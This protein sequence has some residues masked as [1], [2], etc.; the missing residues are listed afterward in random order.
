LCASNDGA[1]DCGTAAT[2]PDIW[3]VFT[4]LRPGVLSVSLCGS[5]NNAGVD[6]GPDT[7]LSIHSG[8]P[9]TIANEL[10]CNDDG[11]LPGCN[12]LDS[13]ARL[14]LP[15]PA[16]VRIRVSHFGSN[17]FRVGNGV[18]AVHAAY[19]C[20]ADY[21]HNGHVEPADINLFV[22]TWFSSLQNHTLDGD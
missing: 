8:C 16:P 21:D 9:A 12:T 17:A 1:A 18:V 11:L 3:Y 10:A 5:R 15:T 19:T 22:N 14:S 13:T 2:N 20:D 4:P 7:V 6:T